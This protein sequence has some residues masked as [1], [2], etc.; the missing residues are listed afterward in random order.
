[1]GIVLAKYRSVV[2]TSLIAKVDFHELDAAD[3]AA[4]AAAMGP[5]CSDTEIEDEE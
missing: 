4:V 2:G 3:S 1:M 5:E